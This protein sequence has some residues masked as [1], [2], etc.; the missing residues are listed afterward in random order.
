MQP[1]NNRVSAAYL[2]ACFGYVFDIIKERNIDT[3]EVFHQLNLSPIGRSSPNHFLN[4]LDYRKLLF[5][6]NVSDTIPEVGLLV[7]ERIGLGD[8]GVLGYASLT[9]RTFG[10]SLQLDVDNSNLLGWGMPGLS[11]RS[12]KDYTEIHFFSEKITNHAQPL[13]EQWMTL[14]HKGTKWKLE[15]NKNFDP[16]EMQFDVPYPKPNYVNDSIRIFGASKINYS[17]NTCVWRYPRKWNEFVL[18]S[19]NPDMESLCRHQLS[20]LNKIK[21]AKHDVIIS[22]VIAFILLNSDDGIPDMKNAAKNINMSVSTLRR[23]LKSG[24]TT[25]AKLIDA[26]RKEKAGQLVGSSQVD[27]KNIAYQI[28]YNHTASF[29]VAFKN[30]YQSTPKEY[31]EQKRALLEIDKGFN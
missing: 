23:R 24:G 5:H 8:L 14:C 30:W 27:L 3:D 17:E 21:L 19:H 28:G 11:M 16:N 26:H 13:I 9:P 31:R 15:L 29:H 4:W 18:D 1:I 7:G 25:Y 10:Q 12:N 22:E 2:K 6:L 20:L